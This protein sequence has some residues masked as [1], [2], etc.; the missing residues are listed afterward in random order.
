ME[1]DKIFKTQ[2][3]RQY[4]IYNTQGIEY[5]TL[6]IS[7]KGNTGRQIGIP[8][9]NRSTPDRFGCKEASGIEEDIDISGGKGLG[10]ENNGEEIN[11]CNTKKES[12]N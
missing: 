5:G 7:Q 11:Y 4:I 1:D 3:K 6:E 2:L 9:R 10:R 12:G 8:K